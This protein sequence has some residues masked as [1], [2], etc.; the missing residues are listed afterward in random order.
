MCKHLSFACFSSHFW[1]KNC[2]KTLK[3]LKTH[4]QAQET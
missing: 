1:G 3:H 4:F 2:F